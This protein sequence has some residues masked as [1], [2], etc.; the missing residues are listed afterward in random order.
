[1]KEIELRAIAEET[2]LVDSEILQEKSE[3]SASFPAGQQA[4]I[5]I[6]RIELTSFQA[7]LE[8]IFQ[9]MRAALIEEHAALLIDEGLKKLQLRFGELDLGSNR[10]HCVLV[11]RTRFP[12]F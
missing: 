10:S 9:K 4:V 6:E 2:R 5:G 11:R 7:T 3:F 8:S 12:A 1:M